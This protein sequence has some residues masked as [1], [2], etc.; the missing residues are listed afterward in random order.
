V[1]DRGKEACE[2]ARKCRPEPRRRP[3][4]R[5]Y[6]PGYEQKIHARPTTPG[7][8]AADRGAE[9]ERHF[10]RKEPP[11]TSNAPNASRHHDAAHK[12]RRALRRR[13]PRRSELLVEL[14]RKR[15]SD[16]QL[17]RLT[18]RFLKAG[19]MVDDQMQATEEGVPQGAG[20]SPLLANV[21]LHYV[22]DECGPAEA[23][24]PVLVICRRGKDENASIRTL[25]PSRLPATGRRR[26]RYFRFS[27]IYSLL[28]SQ[29]L[30][31]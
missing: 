19:V 4:S 27:R 26:S 23:I 15:I 20:L 13:R 30:A 8:R 25:C 17:L 1:T 28:W 6:L 21:Y 22:L 31:C 2:H 16:P 7:E 10:T 24:R 5:Q 18:A 12:T 9:P 3:R 29:F 11:V 14:L